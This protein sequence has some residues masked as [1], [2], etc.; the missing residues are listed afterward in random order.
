MLERYNSLNH[1]RKMYA[2]HSPIPMAKNNISAVDANADRT[3]ATTTLP[4]LSWL[5]HK[6]MPEILALCAKALFDYASEPFDR[7]GEGRADFLD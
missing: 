3:S 7:H 6:S 2:R 4:L 1:R 5:G